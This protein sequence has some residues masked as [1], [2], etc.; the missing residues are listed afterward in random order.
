[1]YMRLLGYPAEKITIL[2]TYNGQ[3]H[4]IRD[5]VEQRCA[6]NPFIGRPHKIATVDKFQGQQNDYILLSLVR[7]KTV[8][9]IRDIRRLTVAL[10]RSRL[11]LYIFGRQNLFASC[12]ELQHTFNLLNKKPTQLKL[13]PHE[14]YSLFGSLDRPNLDENSIQT[15]SDMPGM[16]QFVFDFYKTQIERLKTEQPQVFESIVNPNKKSENDN[17]NTD[18]EEREDEPENE[19]EETEE[20][21]EDDIPFEKLTEDD[22]ATVDDIEM[23]EIEEKEKPAILLDDFES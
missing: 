12:Y 23:P 14:Q 18:E 5:V 2:T 11:G 1:M 21:Q 15:I 13:L 8:G 17:E 10:S 4:L 7:T 20:T 19:M 3:K 16:V 9:H 22:T 6:S